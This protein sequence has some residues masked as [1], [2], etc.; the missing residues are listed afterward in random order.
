VIRVARIKA[1]NFMK[2]VGLEA[3]YDAGAAELDV[4]S[5]DLNRPGLALAGFCDYFSKESVQ[6]IGRQEM[7]YLTAALDD[8]QRYLAMDRLLALPF[9]CLVISRGM[10]PPQGLMQLAVKHGRPVYRSALSTHKL[11]S[12]L[13]GY[14]SLM[15]APR[16]T[17][18]GVLV[19]VYGIGLMITGESG[20]GKSETAL[21]L[22]RRGHRLVAD[23]L[24]EVRR[25]GGDQLIGSAPENIRHFMEIRGIGVINI[26]QM[27]GIGSVMAQKSIDMV[28]HLEI[29]DNNKHYDRI[30]IG[31]ETEEILEV[32]LPKLAVP[33]LP[34]RNLAIF[35]E[36]AARNQ[37]LKNMGYDSALEMQRL[38]D[39][40]VGG[41]EEM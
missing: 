28:A 16:I 13:T 24:V 17:M 34:G 21:E 25:L 30:G 7:T 14:L 15:L 31:E 1:E 29:W 5:P 22:L 11:M 40:Q 33:V 9:P 19:D 38:I 18:H 20:M 3:L 6:V 27:Y 37:R 23:D 26:R 10:E 36:V 35:M 2:A 32:K 39:T 12:A 41:M 4:S 8:D